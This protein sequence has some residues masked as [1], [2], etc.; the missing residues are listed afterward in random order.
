[1]NTMLWP[2][3]L[4]TAIVTPLKDDELDVVALGRVVD[5]QVS[6]GAVGL[7]VGGGT[8]E[9]GVLSLAERR[10]LVEGKIA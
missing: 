6:H 5:H 2:R 7:V 8:G 4:V 10:E 9:F 1:M 3:G